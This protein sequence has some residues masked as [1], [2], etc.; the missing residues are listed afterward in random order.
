MVFDGLNSCIGK[1]K[2]WKWILKNMTNIV[3]LCT[4]LG[5]KGGTFV[6]LSHWAKNIDK[7]KYRISLI[8][9]SPTKLDL[10]RVKTLEKYGVEVI[11]M[12]ELSEL[13]KLYLPAIFK[14][15]KILREKDTVILHT[16]FIQADIIGAIAAK[17]AKVSYIVSSLEGRL[18]PSISL[19]WKKAIYR[20]AYAVLKNKIDRF[21]AISKTTGNDLVRDFEVN[22]KKII[23]IYNGVEPERFPWRK[24]LGVLEERLI[25][26]EP[27]LG[28]FGV[29]G[30]GKEVDSLI[31]SFPL[32]LVQFPMAKLLIVGE[33]KDK[34]LSQR[35]VQELGIENNVQFLSWV[36]D[37]TEIMPAF[38]IFVLPSKAEGMPW[39]VLEAMACAKP[40]IATA[41]GGIPEAVENGKTGI[42]LPD[43]K[44]ESIAQAILSLLKDPERAVNMGR[45]GRKRIEENFTAFHEI[46]KMEEL[47]DSLIKTK[48]QRY[49]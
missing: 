27:V 32:V 1:N 12:P 49:E 48:D 6:H 16:I 13:K 18:I 36:A 26:K 28:Y 2:R 14:L 42:L 5:S 17:I 44:P 35:R 8:F 10:A 34:P 38:D 20:L 23:V 43:S 45:A 15:A 41:V 7:N 30:Y 9:C 19:S 3:W 4:P 47:Y 46:Q 21:I 22:P 24:S 25:K 29:I 33:G 37:I 11:F 40:V 39:S 31:E